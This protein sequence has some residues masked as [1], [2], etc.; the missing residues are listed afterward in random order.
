MSKDEDM[1]RTLTAEFSPLVAQYNK[2]SEEWFPTEFY[3]GWISLGF[4]TFYTQQDIDLSGYAMERKTFYPYSSFEQRGGSTAGTFDATLTQQPFLIESTIISSIP[5]NVDE[6]GAAIAFSPGFIMPSGIAP[7]GRIDRTCILHGEYKLY[8]IDSN[9]A[10]PGSNS[11]LALL[12]REIFSSLEPT[13]ADKLYGYRIVSVSSGE[14][15]GDTIAVP[16]SR[17]LMPGNISSEPTLE[18]MM[19][20]KRS[21]ELANQV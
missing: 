14:G 17:V 18:Y 11:S 16:A 12:Q 2:G 10:V 19:R 6:I 3:A 9:M 20:L 8:T 13:A 21:Y 7:I 15:E 5:L 1:Q 4:G